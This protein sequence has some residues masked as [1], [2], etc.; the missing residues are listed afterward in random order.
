MRDFKLPP[1]GDP[2]GGACCRWISGTGS[3]SES[4]NL[5]NKQNSTT[6]AS[7][8]GLRLTPTDAAAR[9]LISKIEAAEMERLAR[10]GRN[11]IPVVKGMPIPVAVPAPKAEPAPAAKQLNAEKKADNEIPQRRLFDALRMH[12][13]EAQ[14]EREGLIEGRK[15]RAD[16]FVPPNIILEMD[17]FPATAVSKRSRTTA[18]A[19]TFSRNMAS[20]CSAHSPS[21]AWTTQ[22]S[23]SW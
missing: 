7:P 6:R 18:C 10:S 16:I 1:A 17:G 2:A 9:G 8:M 4:E 15:Y 23:P 19:R 21:S 14:W 12:L 11:Q 20:V 22:C 13:P 5:L 3:K